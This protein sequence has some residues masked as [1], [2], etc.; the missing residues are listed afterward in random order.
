MAMTNMYLTGPGE[1]LILNKPSSCERVRQRLKK[2][3]PIIVELGEL[4]TAYDE[5]ENP[6]VSN[7]RSVTSTIGGLLGE[8]E[9]V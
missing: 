1:V 4:R 6:V 9:S 5:S 3:N 7:I 8:T 2:A